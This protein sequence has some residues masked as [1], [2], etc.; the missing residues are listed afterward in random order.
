MS[1]RDLAEKLWHLR[2]GL[3]VLFQSGY[4]GVAVLRHGGLHAEAGFL[5]KPF[6]NGP[7]SQEGPGKFGAANV[8]NIQ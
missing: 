5:Q 8:T 3:K 4:T 6:W 7:F 1:G 2:S